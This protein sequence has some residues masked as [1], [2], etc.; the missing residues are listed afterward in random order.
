MAAAVKKGNGPSQRAMLDVW[1]VRASVDRQ[2]LYRPFWMAK[3]MFGRACAYF[4]IILNGV[5]G[6]CGKNYTYI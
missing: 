6:Q 4:G 2:C 1:I 5:R 3:C